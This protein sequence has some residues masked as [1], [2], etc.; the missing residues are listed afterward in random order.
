MLLFEKILSLSQERY[1]DL[2]VSMVI[3]CP[4]IFMYSLFMEKKIG[5]GSAQRVQQNKQRSRVVVV[6]G[7][8]FLVRTIS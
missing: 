6:M 5:F 4:I 1:I 8:I 7:Q 3:I 2:C